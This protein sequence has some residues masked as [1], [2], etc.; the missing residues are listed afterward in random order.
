M[1]RFGTVSYV[2]PYDYSTQWNY[3]RIQD[4]STDIFIAPEICKIVDGDAI[5]YRR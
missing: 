5:I 1:K 2:F 3:V 4:E